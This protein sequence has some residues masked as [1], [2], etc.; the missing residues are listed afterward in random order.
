VSAKSFL[1]TTI[2]IKPTP[3][4]PNAHLQLLIV[5]PDGTFFG[6]RETADALEALNILSDPEIKITDRSAASGL[7]E[8]EFH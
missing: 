3:L 5:R 4:F 7:P 8:C 6:S 1:A 2:H